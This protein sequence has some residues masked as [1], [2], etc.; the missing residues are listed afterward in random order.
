M[1]MMVMMMLAHR[2]ELKGTYFQQQRVLRLRVLWPDSRA[3]F[4]LKE[5]PHT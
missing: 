4:S 5:Q 3:R 1:V 2:S